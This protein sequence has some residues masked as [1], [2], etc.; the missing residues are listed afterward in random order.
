MFLCA[1]LCVAV[2][3]SSA[4]A[5]DFEGILLMSTSHGTE[6][7]HKMDWSIKGDK[8]RIDRMRENGRSH[9]T[10]R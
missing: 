2:T 5:G 1:G 3:V 6:P 7:P 10:L 4:N 8:A 9:G